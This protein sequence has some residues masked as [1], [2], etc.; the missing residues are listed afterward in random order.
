MDQPCCADQRPGE[1]ALLLLALYAP[2]RD[3]RR[4]GWDRGEKGER[5]GTKG[6]K[7]TLTSFLR[8]R[9]AL[10]R[11]D[12]AVI[13]FG[14]YAF[15]H[16]IQSSKKLRRQGLSGTHPPGMACWG[17][18]LLLLGIFLFGN[19]GR[20]DSPDGQYRFD[21][22]R[23][24]I[25]LQGPVLSDSLLLQA[26]VPVNPKTRKA[27]SFYTA[28]ASLVPVPLM[29]LGRAINGA[30]VRAD[31]FIFSLTSAFAGALIGPLLLAFYR[32]LGLAIAPA[33]GWT[34]VFALAT[35]WWPGSET[36]L[37]QCQHGVVVL[38][39]VLCAYDAARRG[40]LGLALLAAGLVGRIVV[41]LSNA[42]HC[43]VTGD[44]P[45]YWWTERRRDRATSRLPC[46]LLFT[47]S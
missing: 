41:Q 21:V 10:S 45:I 16:S 30:N 13:A 27:Y 36:V 20:I 28:P 14:A 4:I 11:P 12:S 26:P 31:Q 40:G 39:M 29:I 25:N 42:V 23:N 19:P 35:L 1:P 18:F 46:R 15:R 22:A 5:P 47:K 38:A 33:L 44:R 34:F 3:W 7:L 8:P 37:D 24:L 17:A 6:L 32:R 2:Y 9:R 43:S